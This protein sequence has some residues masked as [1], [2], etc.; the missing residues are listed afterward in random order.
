MYK[1]GLFIIAI[2]NLI[3]LPLIRNILAKLDRAVSKA[4]NTK[5]D[6]LELK[7]HVSERYVTKDELRDHLLRIE[8]GIDDLKVLMKR[9]GTQ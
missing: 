8:K 5:E 3:A 2:L 1:T 7:L 4:D 6:I 9:P